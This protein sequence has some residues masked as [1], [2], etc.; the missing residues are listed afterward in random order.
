MEKLM[1]L[2]SGQEIW[3]I[4]LEY[5]VGCE[6]IEMFKELSKKEAIFLWV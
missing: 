4:R 3:K 5:L 1:I 2:E 6:K